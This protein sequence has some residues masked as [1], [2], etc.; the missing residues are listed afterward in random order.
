MARCLHSMFYPPLSNFFI[1][2]CF[3][4]ASISLQSKR[5]LTF[6]TLCLFVFCLSTCTEKLYLEVKILP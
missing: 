6:G 2:H 1:R 5:R 3:C 4:L